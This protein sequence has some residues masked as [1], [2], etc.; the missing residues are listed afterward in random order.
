MQCDGCV[1]G[2]LPL[3]AVLVIGLQELRVLLL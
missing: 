2:D 3:L 1:A